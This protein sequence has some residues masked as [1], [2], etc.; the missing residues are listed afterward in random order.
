MAKELG[1]K[2]L[3]LPIFCCFSLRQF[4]LLDFFLLLP[5]ILAKGVGLVGCGFFIK[6]HGDIG[7]GLLDRISVTPSSPNTATM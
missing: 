6:Q 7:F 5:E 4:A 3:S 1:K 2:A